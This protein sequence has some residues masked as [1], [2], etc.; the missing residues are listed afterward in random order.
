MS[1]LHERAK[2][3]FLEAVALPPAQRRSFVAQAC[4]EDEALRREVESLLAHH[5]PQTLLP[6]TTVDS[7]GWA[8]GP[9]PGPG[10][11]AAEG[12][13]VGRKSERISGLIFAQLFGN[14]RR[15]YAA[16]LA[17]SGFLLVLGVLVYSQVQRAMKVKLE[18]EL[19]TLLAADVEALRIWMTFQEATAA[20]IAADPEVRR[21]AAQLTQLSRDQALSGTESP[22]SSRTD[23]QSVQG[24]AD[25]LPIRPTGRGDGLPIRPTSGSLFASDELRQLRAQLQPL[26]EMH[27]YEGFLLV[28]RRGRIV[29]ANADSLIGDVRLAADDRLL[30][31]VFGDAARPTLL[32]PRPSLI[33]L[34]DQDGEYRAGVPVMFAIAPVRNEGRTAVAGLGL[35]LQPERAFTRILSVARAGQTGDTY[36]FDRS[37]R[38]LSESRFDD[39][40]RAIGLIPDRPQ[41]RSIL[42]VELRDP[43]ADLTR[44]R[45]PVRRRSELP[46]TRMAAAA[47]A[48][49]DGVDVQGYRDYRGVTV[50]GAWTWLD[51]YQFGVATEIAAQEAFA[52]LQYLNLIFGGLFLVIAAAV[53][54]ALASSFAAARLH[55]EVSQAR[56]VGQYTLQK[57]IGAGGMGQVY[58]ARHALLKRPTA[59]KLLRPD[60]ASP[61]TIARFEREVQLTSQLTHPN[62]IEI[63]DFGRTPEGLFYY[64]MEYLPGLTLAE[65][66]R[67]EGPLPAERAVH[68]LRQV[69]GSL[70]EAH[71]S[72]LIHRDIKPQNIML[73][74]R[75]GLWDFVKVL[76]FG[77]V[78]QVSGADAVQLTADQHVSGTPL[79]IAPEVWSKPHEADARADIYALGVVGFQ[80]LTGGDPFEAETLAELFH[81]VT[82]SDPPLPSSRTDARIPAELDE[83]ILACIAKD[84][85]RR[86]AT[87]EAVLA[88]L[89]SDLGLPRWTP[90]QAQAWWA[91]RHPA[92]PST[93]D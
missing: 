35:R 34:Q 87:I 36:A 17:A 4:A 60:Q 88:V 73:C 6:E 2:E 54:A 41:S 42:N 8:D 74:E 21:L 52:P 80:L 66:I 78:K 19:T 64:A 14:L 28:D 3:V 5:D 49:Q 12:H 72:G 76:D 33:A 82:T 59:I 46:L 77:L 58:L 89:E 90:E 25:G 37:G 51:D 83:L 45:R 50:V 84:P 22:D 47:V 11:A 79:Y 20:A 92:A 38:L 43:G 55:R 56:Q 57:P 67:Q 44:G 85:G 62:T 71:G 70:R 81:L 16:V 31:Q 86:P 27:G 18:Q 53:G 26:L 13:A 24:N 68:I 93:A 91:Q 48:G 61:K 63:F 75:G 65:L 1:E 23:W 32:P 40:L 10:R 15:R 29:A 9:S 30:D 69:C 7:N 39:Q